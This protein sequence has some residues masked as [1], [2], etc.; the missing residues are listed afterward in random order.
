MAHDSRFNWGILLSHS[1]DQHLHRCLCLHIGGRRVYFCS[2]C[3]GLY[4]TLVLGLI[5][6]LAGFQVPSW[7]DFTLR[8][9]LP[10]MGALAWGIEQIGISLSK[11]VRL[12]SG[13]LIG[14]GLGWVL[15]IH[16][17]NPWP[18]ELV[19]TSLVLGFILLIGLLGNMIRSPGATDHLT[20][21]LKLA[22][23]ELKKLSSQDKN[24]VDPEA[25]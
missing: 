1:L 19:E 22:E 17:I 20:E 16:L 23:E 6:Q 10:A 5:G 3:V 15:G 8:I 25:D 7:C 21:A 4:V 9:I 11:P 18:R 13:I 2:R 12:L 14:I 24:E